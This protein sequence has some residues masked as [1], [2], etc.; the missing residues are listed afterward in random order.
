M[1][2]VVERTVHEALWL[3]GSAVLRRGRPRGLPPPEIRHLTTIV[4]VPAEVAAALAPLLDRLRRLDPGHVYYGPAQLHVTL[5]NLDGLRVPLDRVE[6]EL[7]GA[8]PLRLAAA[9]LSLSPGTVLVPVRPLDDAFLELRRALRAL[10]DPRPGVRGSALRPLLGR[11][12]FANVVRFSGPVSR[13]FLDEVAGL[14]AVRLGTWTA[15][16]V[17]L[18]QTDRL[19]S[20]DATRV[21]ARVPLRGAA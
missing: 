15:G 21:L 14:R 3:A 18:V 13:A 19:F 10:G 17:E 8:P 11:I 20:P 1:A 12:A 2:R 9:G 16:E 5:A 6:R 7:A 4:R